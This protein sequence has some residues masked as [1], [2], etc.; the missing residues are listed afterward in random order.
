[1]KQLIVIICAELYCF[2][3]IAETLE[4]STISAIIAKVKVEV[5]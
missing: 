3:G 5:I 2:S 1:M 4:I